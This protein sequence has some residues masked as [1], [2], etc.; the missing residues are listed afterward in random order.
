MSPAGILRQPIQEG[1]RT[2]MLNGLIRGP[3]GL[4]GSR[5]SRHFYRVTSLEQ[6]ISAGEEKSVRLSR[7]NSGACGKHWSL[8][9]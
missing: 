2:R 3:G 7:C 5:L 4:S 6:A 8:S 1:D 9:H